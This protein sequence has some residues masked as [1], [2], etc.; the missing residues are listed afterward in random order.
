M[1]HQD[2]SGLILFGRFHGK[3]V[4]MLAR[5]W[6]IVDLEKKSNHLT[7]I[8]PSLLIESKAHRL[9]LRWK[10]LGFELHYSTENSFRKIYFPGEIHGFHFDDSN[11]TFRASTMEIPAK[12]FSLIRDIHEIQAIRTSA[13]RIRFSTEGSRKMNVLSYGYELQSE[14]CI[15]YLHGGPFQRFTNEYNGLLKAVTSYGWPLLAPQYFGDPTIDNS[16]IN[17]SPV[18]NRQMKQIGSLAKTLKQKYKKVFCL[19]HSYG[20]YLGAHLL[21]RGEIDALVSLNGVF[22][23]ETLK[24]ISP[25]TFSS[26]I[27]LKTEDDGRKDLNWF[28]FHSKEDQVVP[29]SKAL[30]SLSRVHTPPKDVRVLESNEHEI[31][32]HNQQKTIAQE[33]DAFLRN[34]T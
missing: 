4:Y 25:A 8:G 26:A 7:P 9:R 10:A 22:D 5:N 13:R 19:S 2:E 3:I 17:Y 29:L 34:L 21:E 28:H 6:L 16:F 1:S 30:E 20:C 18:S 32:D 31:L 12:N 11:L 24:E 33:L 23:L 14:S 27:P 15:L